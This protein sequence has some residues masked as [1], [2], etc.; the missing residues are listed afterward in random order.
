MFQ[1]GASDD[2][3]DFMGRI[4]SNRKA[5]CSS[6]AGFKFNKKRVR[7]IAKVEEMSDTCDGIVYWMS[8]DQ[9]VQGKVMYSCSTT[10][11]KS[12]PVQHVFWTGS[13]LKNSSFNRQRMIF[14][15]LEFI[16]KIFFGGGVITK[17]FPNKP[18]STP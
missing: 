11:T 10:G 2:S 17:Y 1:E 12:G 14:L 6:V 4:A 5:V 7:M 8:R 15:P 13:S 16:L 9:R 3:S 18:F